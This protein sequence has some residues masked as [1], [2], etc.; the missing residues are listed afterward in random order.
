[1]RETHVIPQ[2]WPYN[3]LSC[4]HAWETVYEAC[5]VH[6]A[7]AVIWRH[8]GTLAMPPWI[9]PSCPSCASLRVRTLP[10]STPA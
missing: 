7:D 4:E 5:Y 3:C 6:A 1:M 10:P 8:K 9:D 2:T